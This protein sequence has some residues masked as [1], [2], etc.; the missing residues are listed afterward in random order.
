MLLMLMECTDIHI[1]VQQYVDMAGENSQDTS[2]ESASQDNE[3][4][5]PL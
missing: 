1:R 3:D 4:C 2:E 5:L